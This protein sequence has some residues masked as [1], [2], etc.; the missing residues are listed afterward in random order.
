VLG[1]FGDSEGAAIGRFRLRRLGRFAMGVPQNGGQGEARGG[2]F[3]AARMLQ[4]LGVE[5]VDSGV[6][7][8]SS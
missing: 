3:V 8:E 2:G 1:D 4:V 6:H 5:G 7:R